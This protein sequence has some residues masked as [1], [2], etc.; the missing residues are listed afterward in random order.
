MFLCE[1]PQVSVGVRTKVAR[2]E[3]LA[4]LRL[5]LVEEITL[6]HNDD[7]YH[8]AACPTGSIMV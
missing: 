5:L 1:M 6:M 3:F 2:L 8:L 4:Y 7:P